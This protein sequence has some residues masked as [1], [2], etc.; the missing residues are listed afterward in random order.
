MRC[1]LATR[2]RAGWPGTCPTDW[3]P[4][5]HYRQFG[6]GARPHRLRRLRPDPDQ[7]NASEGDRFG[8]AGMQTDAVTGLYFDQARWYDPQ[9]GR[10]ISIDPTGFTAGD[11]DLYR[12][13]GNGPSN[14][15]DPYG[16]FGEGTSSIW[17]GGGIVVVCTAPDKLGDLRRDFDKLVTQYDGLMGDFNLLTGDLNYLRR[18]KN[19]MRMWQ[20]TIVPNEEGKWTVLGRCWH[21][22]R[23]YCCTACCRQFTRKEV[24]FV[25]KCSPC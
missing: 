7:S 5:R 16:L 14:V 3:A 20:I 17:I 13:V 23:R 10:F 18:I 22:S 21:F 1:W 25:P 12:Y 4:W 8:Y 24:R 19:I 15:V 9:S 6:D 2:P 11:T